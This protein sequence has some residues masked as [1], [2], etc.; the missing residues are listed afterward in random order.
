MLILL[1]SVLAFFSMSGLK[2]SDE[3]L[4]FILVILLIISIL[5]L[6]Y[7]LIS[8]YT[9][10][11]QFDILRKLQIVD[12]VAEQADLETEKSLIQTQTLV[13]DSITYGL[14]IE[15]YLINVLC[16]NDKLQ[17][18]I[19]VMTFID[20]SLNDLLKCNNYYNELIQDKLILNLINDIYYEDEPLSEF[21]DYN[22]DIE[23]NIDLSCIYNDAEIYS[24]NLI[25]EEDIFD[26][27]AVLD[28]NNENFIV[29]N[30][31][32]IIDNESNNNFENDEI[33]K[34]N[35]TIIEEPTDEDQTNFLLNDEEIIQ[36]QD[37]NDDTETIS[38]IPLIPFIIDD[39]F[40]FDNFLEENVI[41]C[42][43]DEFDSSFNLDENSFIE[44]N[45]VLQM[46]VFDLNLDEKIEQNYLILQFTS[47]FNQI[48]QEHEEFISM[49][50]E[51]DFNVNND[52]VYDIHMHYLEEQQDDIDNS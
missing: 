41:E 32:F 6:F 19:D 46:S 36:S 52:N 15:K 3:Y 12:A 2:F 25:F 40:D 29:N 20:D 5:Y 48:N 34:N 38:I 10:T 14:V 16:E 39:E 31:M 23:F 44:K 24:S 13:N 4:L 49:N 21:E 8:S 1:L 9:I 33:N 30:N 45:E 37:I 26:D 47:L 28:V 27:F 7:D 17:H 11:V 51:E 18:Q 50:N 35:D 22:Q 43:I 42:I